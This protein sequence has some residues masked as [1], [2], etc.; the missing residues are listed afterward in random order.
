MVLPQASELKRLAV[1]YDVQTELWKPD[2]PWAEMKRADWTALF[3][4]GIA[5]SGEQEQQSA[6]TYVLKPVDGRLNYIRRG[7]NVRKDE[8]QAIQEADVKL[9][10]IS[11]HVSSA[12]CVNS[13]SHAMKVSHRLNAGKAKA[14]KV[15][16]SKC[17]LLLQ[18][19][20]TRACRR[21]QATLRRMQPEPA[22]GIATRV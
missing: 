20:S 2:K 5:A 15:Q 16:V 19:T 7:R 10:A 1:Y 17:K 14:A 3:Q 8:S 13:T 9:H 6:H 21:S 18:A 12:S 11:L 22:T 4:P